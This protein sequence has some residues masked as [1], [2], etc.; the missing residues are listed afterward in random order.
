MKMS[1]T[2]W[3]IARCTLFLFGIGTEKSRMKYSRNTIKKLK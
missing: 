1:V 2:K 3:N